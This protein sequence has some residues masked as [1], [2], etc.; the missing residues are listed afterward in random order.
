MERDWRDFKA[1]HGGEEGARAAFQKA[2]GT[3]FR[4]KYP[5]KAHEVRP[6]PGY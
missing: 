4:K 6:N 1:L 2:C 3:L 5:G